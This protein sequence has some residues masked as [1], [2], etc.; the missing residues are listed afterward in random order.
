MPVVGVFRYRLS[1][2]PLMSTSAPVAGAELTER[3]IIIDEMIARKRDQRWVRI[4]GMGHLPCRWH[5]SADES[6]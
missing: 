4:N 3:S 1:R 6:G 2:Q 5:L